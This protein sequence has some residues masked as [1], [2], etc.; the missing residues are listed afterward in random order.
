MKYFRVPE[1]LDQK[2]I[3][4]DRK[5]LRFL[6]GKELYTEHEVDKHFPWMKDKL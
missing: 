6:I 4:K 1:K 2:P 5:Y 3:Y